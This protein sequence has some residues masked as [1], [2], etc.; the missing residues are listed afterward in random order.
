MPFLIIGINAG[1]CTDEGMDTSAV[2]VEGEGYC[3]GVL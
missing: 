1:A 2:A 3:A